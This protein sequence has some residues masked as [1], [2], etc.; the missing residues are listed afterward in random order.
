MDFYTKLFLINF[1]SCMGVS[2]FDRFLL[3]DAIQGHA[4]FGIVLGI[5]CVVM[6]ASFPA[7]L[8]YLIASN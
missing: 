3:E 5:W 6:L 1:V 8:I 2:L 7:Y 4:F